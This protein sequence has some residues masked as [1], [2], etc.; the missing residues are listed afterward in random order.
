MKRPTNG[1]IGNWVRYADYLE[2]QA[3]DDNTRILQFMNDE[4]RNWREN[5]KVEKQL[6]ESKKENKAM[7]GKTIEFILWMAKKE[8][9]DIAARWLADNHHLDQKKID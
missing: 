3:E 5:S 6:K 1:K 4:D 2:Q 9:T 8:N 7:A